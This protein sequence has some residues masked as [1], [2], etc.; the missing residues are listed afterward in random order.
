MKKECS[1]WWPYP[2]VNMQRNNG[3]WRCKDCYECVQDTDGSK[4]TK[5]VLK[6]SSGSDNRSTQKND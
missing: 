6:E 1:C 3:K 2:N 4:K 5:C